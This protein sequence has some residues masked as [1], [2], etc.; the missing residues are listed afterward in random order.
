M[1]KDPD[2]KELAAMLSQDLIDLMEG[3]IRGMSREDKK[4]VFK[5][6][7]TQLSLYFLMKRL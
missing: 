5:I 1:S 2:P 6:V 3:A 4:A 7:A